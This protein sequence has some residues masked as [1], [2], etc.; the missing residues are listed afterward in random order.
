MCACLFEIEAVGLGVPDCLFRY[1]WPAVDEDGLIAGK[2]SVHPPAI[3]LVVCPCGQ[4]SQGT[5]VRHKIDRRP[6]KPGCGFISV[7]DGLN[8]SD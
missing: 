1:Q 7:R 6:I 5:T 2:L 3:G 8:C 4:L